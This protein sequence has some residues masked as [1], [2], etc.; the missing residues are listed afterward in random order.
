MI[1]N[2]RG[3][4]RKLKV[5]P[6]IPSSAAA[7]NGWFIQLP[8]SVTLQIALRKT[9]KSERF[10]PPGPRTSKH[11]L[12]KQ[13]PMMDCGK[14]RCWTGQL[15][16]WMASCFQPSE[17]S[18]HRLGGLGITPLTTTSTERGKRRRIYQR[19][20]GQSGITASIFCSA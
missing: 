10:D 11:K 2:N 19:H 3:Y 16:T 13:Q 12:I 17:E 1:K 14:Y 18:L 9:G 8:R 6:K 15:I 5:G 4:L 20:S 7:L